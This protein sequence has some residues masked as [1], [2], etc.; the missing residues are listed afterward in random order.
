MLIVTT[1]AITGKEIIETYGFCKGSSVRAKNV[2]RDILASFKGLVGG[3]ITE[4]TNMMDESRKLAVA[5]L[6]SDAESMGANAIVGFRIQTSSISQ[7]VS[8]VTAYGTAV[9]IND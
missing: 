2:G 8:E 1:E 3:E 6:V 5:R 7:G 4:Y 9:K